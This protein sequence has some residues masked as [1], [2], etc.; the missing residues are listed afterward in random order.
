MSET[1]LKSAKR[2]L[3]I[4]TRTQADSK[5]LVDLANLAS[6]KLSKWE[7]DIGNLSRALTALRVTLDEEREKTYNRIK[8]IR[9]LEIENT[10]LR[11]M[12]KSPGTLWVES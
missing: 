1:Q 11:E 7:E 2:I 12:L 5:S 3:E 10:R 6:S 8:Q 4:A 9:E